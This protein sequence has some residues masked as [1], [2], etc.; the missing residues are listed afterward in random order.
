[1]TK[2]E[3]LSS[4]KIKRVSSNLRKLPFICRIKELRLSLCLTLRDVEKETGVNNSSLCL[5]ERGA[6]LTLS[7][8]LVL[9][10]FFGRTIEELW[11]SKKDK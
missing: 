11:P 7:N 6:D 3:R 4:K 2:A 1:M 8:A 9:A 10:T 5:I